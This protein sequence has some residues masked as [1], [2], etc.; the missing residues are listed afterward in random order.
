MIFTQI[1][2]VLVSIFY[3]FNIITIKTILPGIFI[4]YWIP[5]CVVIDL[6]ELLYP[7]IF[8]RNLYSKYVALTFNNVPHE[9]HESHESHEE[10]IKILDQNLMKGTFFI[11]SDNINEKNIKIF[12][13]AVKNGHQLANH[14]KTNTVHYLKNKRDL[15]KEILDCD[16]KIREIYTL[17]GTSLPEYMF[18]RPGYGLFGPQMLEIVKNL[19]YKLAMGSVY[20]NDTI[21]INPTINYH[22][23]IN[24]IERGDII[25]MHDRK[26]TSKM[27]PDLLEWMKWNQIESITLDKL[28]ANR[29]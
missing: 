3:L 27:L 1:F 20:P 22:Y 5:K 10:I 21:I 18:Y 16:I 4:F 29:F 13:D 26:W 9:S 6:I 25:I 12:V 15:A 14:G 7:K 8:M 19:G 23:L 28:F 24:H 11:V 17:A 2:L